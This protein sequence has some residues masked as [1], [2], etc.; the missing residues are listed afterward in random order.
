M[1]K[2]KMKVGIYFAEFWCWVIFYPIFV[3]LVTYTFI[4]S[5]T[6]SDELIRG[7]IQSLVL[8]LGGFSF[9]IWN[10][11]GACRVE[12]TDNNLYVKMLLRKTKV[13]SKEELRIRYAVKL[14]SIRSHTTIHP[15]LVVGRSISDVCIFTK[16]Y[17]HIYGNRYGNS[18]CLIGLIDEK[19]FSL[20]TDWWQ[21]EIELPSRQEWDDDCQNDFYPKYKQEEVKKIQEFYTMIEKYNQSI[22]GKQ[23]MARTNEANIHLP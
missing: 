20:I 9:F 15:C 11:E 5:A 8:A 17:K 4:F 16:T 7:L 1:K 18:Y 10:E 13:Y 6:N 14:R 2:I 22:R 19:R 21:K 23:R 12:L 3:G